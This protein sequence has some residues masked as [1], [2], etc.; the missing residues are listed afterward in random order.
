MN[1]APISLKA[2]SDHEIIRVKKYCH[3]TFTKGNIK[4]DRF[5]HNT[6]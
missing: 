1:L 2:R 4:I 6:S 5:R 3:S